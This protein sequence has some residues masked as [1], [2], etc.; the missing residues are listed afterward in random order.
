MLIYKYPIKMTFLLRINITLETNRDEI[1]TKLSRCL[2]PDLDYYA[3]YHREDRR[4]IQSDYPD[5]GDTRL[6]PRRCL[7]KLAADPLSEIRKAGATVSRFADI[8]SQIHF[9]K[10]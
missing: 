1:A 4:T 10:I 9:S 3:V 8:F 2:L 7:G 6:D 5:F